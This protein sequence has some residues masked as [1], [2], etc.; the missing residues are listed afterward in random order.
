MS[1]VL[2]IRELDRLDN[3]ELATLTLDRHGAVIGRSPHA[4]WSLPDPSNLISSRHCEIG[5]RDGLYLLTDQST[6]GTYLNGAAERLR[7]AHG[8]V[9]GDRFAVGHYTI[10]ASLAGTKVDASPAI[11]AP[12]SWADYPTPDNALVGTDGWADAP[13]PAQSGGVGWQRGGRPSAAAAQ[14]AGTWDLPAPISRPSAWS[15]EPAAATA[16]AAN[17]VWGRLSEQSEID[18]SRGSFGSA[19]PPD[20]DWNAAVAK[21]PDHDGN[22]EPTTGPAVVIAAMSAPVPDD[23]TAWTRFIET[24]G[25]PADRLT[26]KPVDVIAAAGT[27]LRQ[28]IG[29]LML[30]IDARARAKGQLGVQATGLELDG[31]NPLKF[32]RS[33]D[34]ALA[35][36]LG[37]PERG[38]MPAERAIEDAFQ[39]L[40]AHQMATLSAMRGA[41]EGT[42]GRFSPDAIRSGIGEPTGLARWF[43]AL[44][45]ARHWDAYVHGFEGVVRGADEAFMDLFAKEFRLHYDRHIVEMKERR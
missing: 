45:R 41:L 39:D 14:S 21:A 1:L 22:G 8:L 31:N 26:R 19:P 4:D 40:Q 27:V 23:S 37:E 43:P 5:Y 12:I 32:V 35:Q 16:P 17:D 3:G 36:M 11:E 15:S 2:T 9:D 28:L 6:N 33:P 18:W 7:G 13:E 30:M 34:L 42:L 24:S 10:L 29:G 20:E 25:V 44:H 38:F